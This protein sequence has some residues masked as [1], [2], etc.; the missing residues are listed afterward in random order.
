MLLRTRVRRDALSVAGGAAKP[1]KIYQIK[2]TLHGP[3]PPIWRRI[4]VRGDTTL[5]ELH[6]IL[7][8]TLGWTDTHLHQFIIQGEQYGASDENQGESRKTRDERKYT[9]SELVAG[10]STPFA[11]TYNFGDNWEHILEVEK[12]LP[13]DKSVHYPVCL[14]GAHACPPE[15]VGGIPGYENFREAITDPQHPDHK[16]LSEWIGDTFDPEKFDPDEVN[17]LLRAMR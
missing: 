6:R 1:V 9:L 15:D 4:Q 13:P 10:A 14:A 5:A 12:T 3:R 8:C 11:Y 2:V 7:Q 16:E 17:Q